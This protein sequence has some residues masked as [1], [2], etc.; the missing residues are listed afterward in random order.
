MSDA[1][2][3]LLARSNDCPELRDLCDFHGRHPEVLDFLVQ[4]IRLRLDSGFPAFSYRSLWEYARWQLEMDKGPSLTF[5]MN[6][7]LNPFY[8]RAITILQPEFNGHARFRSPENIK[9]DT[10]FG[11]RIEPG[12][13]KRPK[14]YARRLQWADGT[15]LEKGWRPTTRHEPKPVNSR[16]SIHL[17]AKCQAEINGI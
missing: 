6:D 5:K 15:S 1:M 11:T 4:E 7:H 14:N 3:E 12:P 10:V 16:P 13:H 2:D 8:G 17:C 9:A